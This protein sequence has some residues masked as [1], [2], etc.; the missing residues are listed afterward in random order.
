[1]L[2][3]HDLP[4]NA[5][6]IR[7]GQMWGWDCRNAPEHRSWG[8]YSPSA[9]NADGECSGKWHVCPQKDI[10]LLGFHREERKMFLALRFPSV[11]HS[12]AAVGISLTVESPEEGWLDTFPSVCLPEVSMVTSCC[13]RLPLL[14]KHLAIMTNVTW[15]VYFPDVKHP[16]MANIT[17]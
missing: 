5:S 13:D 9:E 4:S 16:L 7:D 17:S 1:M 8:W 12:R 14:I 2:P 6:K 10:Y 3:K 11:Q 15:N